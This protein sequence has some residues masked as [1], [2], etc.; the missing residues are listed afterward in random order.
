MSKLVGVLPATRLPATPMS[1]VREKSI[2]EAVASSL[3]ELFARPAQTR[4][5]ALL[6]HYPFPNDQDSVYF[7]RA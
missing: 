1:L 4:I 7:A 5:A 6:E 2:L 3:T